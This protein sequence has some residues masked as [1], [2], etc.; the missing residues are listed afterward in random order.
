MNTQQIIQI[1]INSAKILSEMDG[2]TLT[3]QKNCLHPLIFPE[4]IQKG[5]SKYIHRI[6]EQELRL[7][8]AFALNQT[9]PALHY[10]IETPTKKKYRLG[11]DINN[12]SIHSGNLRSG[13]ID[14]TLFDFISQKYKRVLNIEFKHSTKKELIAKDIFKLINEPDDGALIILLKN[15]DTGTFFNKLKKNGLFNKLQDLLTLYSSYWHDQNKKLLFVIM[16]ISNKDRI[17]I[18]REINYNDLNNLNRIFNQSD[19]VTVNQ[20]VGWN[21]QYF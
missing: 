6:S 17:I 13:L 3:A 11:D 1:C 4:K 15:T 19:M 8:F 9:Y 2:E 18:H 21:N 14:L 10:S 20:I 5:G 12:F 16:S 7:L